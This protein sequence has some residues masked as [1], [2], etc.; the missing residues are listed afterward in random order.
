V[1]SSS[2]VLVRPEALAFRSDL[3][4]IDEEIERF[5]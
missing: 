2:G 4:V 3:C 5:D 1:E